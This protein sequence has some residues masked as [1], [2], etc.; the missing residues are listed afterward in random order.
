MGDLSDHFSRH[1]FACNCGCGKDT[2]DAELLTICEIVREIEGG[3]VR[4]ASGHRCRV[5]NQRAGGASKSQHLYGRA[6]DLIVRDPE[7]TAL[8][9]DQK[10][11]DKYGIGVYDHWIHVDSR[12]DRARWRAL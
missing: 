11:P 10:F 5:H 7:H 12:A 2:V 6:A 4:V 8:I 9:L 1:E 3:P